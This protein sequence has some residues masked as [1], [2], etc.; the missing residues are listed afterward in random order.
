MRMKVCKRIKKHRR[1]GEM[2]L[3]SAAGILFMVLLVI[4]INSLC[5]KYLANVKAE[6]QPIGLP[7]ALSIDD[8]GALDADLTSSVSVGV[9]TITLTEDLTD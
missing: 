2:C 3:G 5:K 8:D 9:G 7:V 4:L 6:F 1:K